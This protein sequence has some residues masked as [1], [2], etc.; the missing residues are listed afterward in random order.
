MIR[1]ASA[2]PLCR[3]T[4]LWTLSLLGGSRA[5][6]A[7]PDNQPTS[8][9]AS[10][11]AAVPELS[12]TVELLPGLPRSVR[13]TLATQAPHTGDYVLAA[14]PH[15]GGQQ[16]AEREIHDLRVR[17]AAGRLLSAT[18]DAQA[19]HRFRINAAPDEPLQAQWELRAGDEDRLAAGGNV[20]RPILRDDLFH[21]IPEIGLLVPDWCDDEQPA[22]IQLHW[23][24]FDQ[25]GWTVV[26]SFGVGTESRTLRTTPGA[27]RHGIFVAGHIRVEQR[28]I[29]GGRLAVATYG[30]DWDFNDP[31]WADLVEKVV[32]VEREFFNDFSD[33]F[34]LVTLVP[35]GQR[36]PNSISLGGTGL[37]NAFALFS[38]PGLSF[39][40]NGPY[41]GRVLHL[42]AH[43][44]FHNW[45]G[46]RIRR[47]EP[48]ELLY[49]FSEGFTDFYAA[50]LLYN[51]GLQTAEQWLGQTNADLRTYWL[52]PVRNESAERIR[53]DFWKSSDVRDLPY[54][55]GSAVALAIDWEIRRRT[56]GKKSLD[57]L[58][59]ELLAAARAGEKV[60]PD[61]LMSRI[62][63]WTSAD[64][65]G[66]IRA[67]V[68]QGATL[69]LPH[70]LF[71][72]ALTF[73]MC[74]SAP[75][76]PG[77]DVDASVKDKKIQGVAAGSTAERAGLR[78]GQAVLG[79]SIY[80]GN[81]DKPIKIKISDDGGTREIEFLPR[82]PVTRIPCL[83]MEKP[84]KF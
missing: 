60:S 46:D 82:G 50:R 55:R 8:T 51:A 3:F 27:F 39:A 19:P 33:E 14:Q 7:P 23:R 70:D 75:F 32:R 17:G 21:W 36:N 68:E 80:T 71:S 76:T 56:D 67:V 34:F 58:M 37:T 49:W 54:K 42:L 52:S 31:D 16:N 77:F 28:D 45:N 29:R 61:N 73:D 84:P 18:P 24:G 59:R 63:K 72:P 53:Q 9:P 65:A 6:A 57:D 5:W 35:S 15:W 1:A 22:T 47:A 64:F 48:E 26:S 4:A 83:R 12:Y 74:E 38:L 44:Y 81:T 20:Y 11:A 43:E 69:E 79:A 30:T 40:E 62:A 41:R 25:P 13:I 66:R 10:Q 78:D 2:K